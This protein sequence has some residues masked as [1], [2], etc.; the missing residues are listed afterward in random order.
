MLMYRQKTIAGSISFAVS[1]LVISIA[2][3]LIFK[4]S[5]QQIINVTITTTVIATITEMVSIKGW[6]N[7]TVPM[8][9]LL[10]LLALIDS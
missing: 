3:G 6:D 1:A 9:T 2:W 8:V 5:A 10:V 4:F 7:I